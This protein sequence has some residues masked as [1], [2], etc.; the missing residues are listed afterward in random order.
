MDGESKY[1]APHNLQILEIKPMKK[2]LILF[3]V[4]LLAAGIV[5]SQCSFHPYPPTVVA[6]GDLTGLNAALPYTT[7][8]TPSSD[9]EF[10]II[11]N[12]VYDVTT[13]SSYGTLLHVT[14]TDTFG[15]DVGIQNDPWTNLYTAYSSQMS[16]HGVSGNPIKIYVQYSG[17]SPGGCSQS[18]DVHYRVVQ[19]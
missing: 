11:T 18:Y 4:L 12:L 19:Y 2:I 14:W 16:F 3:S 1:L 6:S 9:G 10:L 5:Y 8:F 17:A 7:I 13:C 15:H